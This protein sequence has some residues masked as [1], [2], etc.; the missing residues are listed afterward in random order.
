MKRVLIKR[1][2]DEYLTALTE[3][4]KLIEFVRDP[5][6]GGSVVGN[7]Y[8]GFVKKINIGFIFLDIGLEKQAF[9]DSRDSREKALF[10]NNKLAVKQGDTL[11]VQVLKDPFDEKGAVV[12]GNIAA[13]GRFIVLSKSTENDKITFSRKIDADECDRLRGVAK[14]CIPSGFSAIFRT[15]AAGRSTEEICAEIPHLVSNFDDFKLWSNIKAPATLRQEPPIL[16]TLQEICSDD[17]D[18]I[19]TDCRILADAYENL[20]LQFFENQQSIFDHF[21]LQSQIDKLKDRRV[22]LNSGAFIVIDQ[23]E[24]CVVIDVNT[25]KSSSKQSDEAKLKVNKEAAKEIARQLRLRNLS[26]IIIVDFIAIKTRDAVNELIELLN[27]EFAKDRIPTV[28][29]GMTALGLM[30][31]TRKRARGALNAR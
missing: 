22:W 9:L 30:E 1:S 20:R 7:I 4:G 29:V 25:G 10:Q 24:A 26:G 13:T 17:V 18:E 19:L 3:N 28:V 14:E 23:V 31:I 6:A 5:L 16:K 15:A 8:A 21:F 11:I 12:S 2:G 27:Q